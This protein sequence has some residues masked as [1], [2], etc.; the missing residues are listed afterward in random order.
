MPNLASMTRKIIRSVIKPLTV[1]SGI[2]KELK[3]QERVILA[4]RKRVRETQSVR[5]EAIRSRNVALREIKDFKTAEKERNETLHA[6]I[7]TDLIDA[8]KSFDEAFVAF[9]QM[10]HRFKEASKARALAHYFIEDSHFSSLGHIGAGIWAL[11]DEIPEMA[12]KHFQVAGVE[13]ALTLCPTEY[14]Q[15][16]VGTS[17]DQG[18]TELS[19]FLEQ[20]RTNFDASTHLSLT[21]LLA[22]HHA[23]ERFNQE[24]PHLIERKNEN[25]FQREED[26]QLVDWYSRQMQDFSTLAP[27]IPSDAISVAIMDYKL[28]DL[29][30][31][32]SNRGDYVQTL[33]G[34]ANLCRFSKVEFIGDNE[35]SNLLNELKSDI[36]PGRVID[37]VVAKVQPVELNRDFSHGRQYPENTWLICNG[38]FMH[39]NY[40]GE[41]DFPF[42]E[43]INP[44]F[45]S[46]HVNNPDVLNEEV[47]KQLKQYEPIGCRDWTT[48]YRLRDF[49]V[50]AF[51]SGCLTSTVGQILPQ[52]QAAQSKLLAQV[53]A[54]ID[55]DAFQ[56]WS[57]TKFSQEGDYVKHFS[58]V[59]GVKD[60]RDMLQTYAPFTK[61]VTSRLHCYLP[62]RSM[63][64]SVDF[65]PRNL[66]DIRFEGLIELTDEAFTQMRTGIE[67]KLERI[68][69]EI[70]N[71]STRSEVMAV[72]KQICADDV[73]FAH[74]YCSEFDQLAS[75]EIDIAQVTSNI[76]THATHFNVNDT[77]DTMQL[78]FALDQNLKDELMVVLD[79]IAKHTS[80]EKHAHILSRG[81]DS[82]Y[83]SKV[84][85]TFPQFSFSFYPFDDVDYGNATRMLSHT[86][87]STLDRLFL[88][89]LLKEA[90]KVLYLD[91]DILVC[92]DVASLYDLNV[93]NHAI[94]ARHSA[95]PSWRN[96][97]RL[98]TW[99]SLHLDHQKAWLLRKWLHH[100]VN[101]KAVGFNAGVL[102]LNLD[103]MRACNFTREYLPFVEHYGFNDQDALNI[104]AAGRVLPIEPEWNFIP[105]LDFSESP[106]IIHWAGPN[107]P[108]RTQYVMHRNLFRKHRKQLLGY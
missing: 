65:V 17:R 43:T 47:A 99:A 52:A 31:T 58:L 76:A 12:L 107:K 61:V 82:D 72:W 23:F 16:L 108:W 96:L 78:A 64:L 48:V 81:L 86:T 87:V 105:N 101:M 18:L 11:H 38:W 55:E 26:N 100:N 54:R 50:E 3:H 63:G 60:A 97:E 8:G 106:K 74:T 6:D 22:K 57:I 10:S 33:A 95:L 19:G 94:A 67:Q 103:D 41:M 66:S 9:I 30:R 32:S 7:I 24:L 34:L 49:G 56:D 25:E 77:A 37:D 20:H 80:R 2:D 36:H 4:E 75:T 45:I 35:L 92:A 29:S 59:E 73:A 5:D 89:E 46:F 21:Q 69:R 104:Y 85:N 68:W 79:S 28:L 84:V 70:L 44:I 40:K 13:K 71:G 15:S 102:L 98:T 39:R 62:T 83:I 14:F 90:S 1:I 42:P 51:F 27:T 91:I 53:E 88:P 93:T